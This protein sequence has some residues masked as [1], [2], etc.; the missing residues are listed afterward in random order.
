MT[1]QH[2]P[3]HPDW[4][5]R[6]CG[7]DWPCEPARDALSAEYGPDRVALA[8][9]MSV[10][11]HRAANDLRDVPASALYQRFIAWTR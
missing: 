10:E 2:A 6:V 5:C 11:L 1:A 9:S 8:V 7:A 3:T 4:L